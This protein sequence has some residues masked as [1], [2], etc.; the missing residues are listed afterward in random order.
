M[1]PPRELFAYDLYV[2]RGL[3]EDTETT[4]YESLREALR[5]G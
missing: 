2:S 3:D 1:R 4:L 5:R